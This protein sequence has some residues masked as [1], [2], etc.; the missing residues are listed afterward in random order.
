MTSMAHPTVQDRFFAL[1]SRVSPALVNTPLRQ[2]DAVIQ[3]GRDNLQTL[4]SL[5]RWLQTHHPEAGMPYWSVR[6]WTLLI[7]Q[8]VILTVV[9][10][11]G[12]GVL[13][14]LPSLRQKALPG[15]VAGFQLPATGW[16]SG[17]DQELV[18]RAGPALRELCDV[19]L[20][21]LR[22]LTLIKPLSA[23]RLVAD[24]LLSAISG[25]RDARPDLNRT[26]LLAL[27][28]EWLRATGLQGQS[29]LQTLPLPG[30]GESLALDR[31]ACCMHYRRE[32]GALCASCP[33][34]KDAVRRA[35]LIEELSCH[36]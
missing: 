16:I 19:L 5:Y 11:H 18:R 23:L 28:D 9:G 30:G 17:R 35:R 15:M 34:Q 14:P 21:E 25:L 6:C 36:A 1:T 24:S 32:D 31:K 20:E 33:K 27:A 22:Q 3:M 26:D 8:P 29:A 13:P 4:T 12:A 10:V 2:D 7:W